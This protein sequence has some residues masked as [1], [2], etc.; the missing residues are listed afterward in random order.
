MRGRG[1]VRVHLYFPACSVGLGVE[2]DKQLPVRKLVTNHEIVSKTLSHSLVSTQPTVKIYEISKKKNITNSATRD[3]TVMAQ[4]SHAVFS[5]LL[6]H[7]SLSKRVMPCRY[8][9]TV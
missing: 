3:S 5:V 4:I 2:C 6:M 1:R 7:Y 9:R 8:L